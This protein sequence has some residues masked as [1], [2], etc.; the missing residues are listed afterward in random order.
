MRYKMKLFTLKNFCKYLKLLVIFT[1]PP[2]APRHNRLQATKCLAS[3]LSHTPLVRAHGAQTGTFCNILLSGRNFLS[4]L[5]VKMCFFARHLF[6]KLRNRPSIARKMSQKVNSL[7]GHGQGGLGLLV[8][9]VL[10]RKTRG[11]GLIETLVGGAIG[12]VVVAGTMKSLQLSLESSLVARSTLAESDIHHTISNI[13]RNQD[14]CLANFDPKAESLPSSN[15]IGL[16][17]ADRAWGVGELVQLV[18]NAGTSGTADDVTALEK[19][20]IFK[21]SLKIVK[22]ELKGTLPTTKDSTTELKKQEAIRSLIVYYKKEGMGAYSTVGGSDC[23]AKDTANN[24]TEDLSGCYFHQCSVDLRLD[25][26]ATTTTDEGKCDGV[27]CFS[28]GGGRGGKPDCYTVEGDLNTAGNTLVGCGNTDKITAT[29]TTAI[30]YSAGAELESDGEYNTFLGVGAGTKTETGDNSVFIGWGA[31]SNNTTGS[32]NTFIG[33][34]A[35]YNDPDQ[36]GGT[37][38]NNIVIGSGVK[39]K[40]NAENQINIGNIIKAKKFDDTD[41]DG[42]TVTRGVIEV[43]NEDGTKCIKLSREALTC[44]ENKYF[45]GFDDDGEKICDPVCPTQSQYHW[46]PENICHKCPRDSPVYKTSLPEG[47][48]CEECPKSKPFY[49]LN[50]KQCHRLCYHFMGGGL[51]SIDHICRCPSSRPKLT[52]YFD[53]MCEICPPFHKYILSRNECEENCPPEKP[54]FYAWNCHRCHISMPVDKKGPPPTCSACPGQSIYNFVRKTCELTC[55]TGQTAVNN[56]CQCTDKS[57]PHFYEKNGQWKC[58]KC[59]QSEYEYNGQCNKCPEGKHDSKGKCCL[60]GWHNSNDKCCPDGKYNS[61][62]WCC[63]NDWYR[64]EF[65]LAIGDPNPPG[66]VDGPVDNT[67]RRVVKL[68]CPNNWRITRNLSS[69]ICC[70]NGTYNSN[71]KCCLNGWHNSNGRCCPDGST[72]NGT[73]CVYS[74]PTCKSGYNYFPDGYDSQPACCTNG[75]FCC[76]NGMYIV[77]DQCGP[78][79]YKYTNGR[80]CPPNRHYTNGKCCLNGWHNSNGKCC[81]K[82]HHHSNGKCCQ[83]ATP[84]LCPFA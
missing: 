12:A 75:G 25:D 35:G 82:N 77:N 67:I 28:S 34:S 24:I 39:I 36:T 6:V 3:L 69:F 52:G 13:L 44:D 16:Y 42:N 51:G 9:Q 74:E 4:K 79:G 17:G 53:G 56:I 57:T 47:P 37:G 1:P 66:A 31:G 20:E 50:T 30:G 55:P 10:S 81:P 61:N 49:R 40:T 27:D 26:P 63:P 58:N 62:G 14:D 71:G 48:R 84:T 15:A 23:Q 7:R 83:D 8:K 22:M 46:K 41:E 45:R 5:I 70:P 65:E 29:G 76:P 59:L 78:I 54:H 64:D 33:H 21:S 73:E 18:K 11:I 60:N 2:P 80:F 19:G 43:C 68:C 32:D 72:Y 38:S